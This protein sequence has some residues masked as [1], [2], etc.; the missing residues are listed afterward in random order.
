MVIKKKN[1]KTKTETIHFF[2]SEH[3]FVLFNAYSSH[4]YNLLK[5][6]YPSTGLVWFLPATSSEQ[7]QLLQR[8]KQQ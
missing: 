7:H 6:S 1:D 4:C 5:H 2:F 8:T 3:C